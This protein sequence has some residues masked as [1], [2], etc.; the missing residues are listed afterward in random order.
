[1]TD[2]ID[3]LKQKAL[4]ELEDIVSI[5]SLEAW[6]VRYLGRKSELT[7]ILRGLAKLPLEE[8]KMAGACA[9]EVKSI[10]EKSLEENRGRA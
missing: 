10:L 4:R 8:R 1:M 5:K 9:N 2:N 6:Q 7:G 3:E